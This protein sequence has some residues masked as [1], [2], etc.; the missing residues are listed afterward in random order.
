MFIVII[1]SYHHRY[2][3]KD[4][5][6]KARFMNLLQNELSASFQRACF[7]LFSQASLLVKFIFLPLFVLDCT[8]YY[9]LSKFV[10]VRIAV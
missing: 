2:Y 4:C 8:C 7:V 10:C 9:L 6:G 3:S 5:L 1:L